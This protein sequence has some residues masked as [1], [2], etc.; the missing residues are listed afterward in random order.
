M[1]SGFIY[2]ASSVFWLHKWTRTKLP[3]GSAISLLDICPEKAIIQKY[4]W[5]SMNIAALFTVARKW[6]QPKQPRYQWISVDEWIKKKCMYTMEC[7]SAMKNKW[8]WVIWTEVDKPR[9][10]LSWWAQITICKVDGW[11]AVALQFRELG[12]VL[13]EDLEGW[14]GE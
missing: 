7:Y 13:C 1:F 14:N 6:K 2:I 8:N 3:Y 4:T 5:T 11:W 10:R 12:L 9:A